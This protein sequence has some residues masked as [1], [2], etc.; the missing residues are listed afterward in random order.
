MIMGG[1]D[2]EEDEVDY[3]VEGQEGQDDSG[4]KREKKR[5]RKHKDKKDKKKDKHK[6]K[7]KKKDK[8][9]HKKSKDHKGNEDANM[10]TGDGEGNEEN[11]N[12]DGDEH[13]AGKKKRLKRTKDVDEANAPQNKEETIPK[14]EKEADNN[15]SSLID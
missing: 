13:L 2:D 6:K 10:K 12:K 11:K 15:K 5:D 7:D 1:G 14:P 9:K 3:V 4:K 8:K